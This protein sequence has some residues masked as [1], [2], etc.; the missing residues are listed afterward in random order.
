MK[1]ILA[2]LILVGAI[3]AAS[4]NEAR[5]EPTSFEI[6]CR[7]VYEEFGEA[8]AGLDEPIVVVS[9]VIKLDFWRR[10]QGVY[11]PGEKYV[12]IAPDAIEPGKTVIHEM[13][14]YILHMKQLVPDE[15]KCEHERI[16]RMIAG[17]PWEDEQKRGYGCQ[18]AEPD[19]TKD[20]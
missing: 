4:V 5:R 16:A 17:H 7:G 2:I 12:F 19:N 15:D 13:V 8:C 11:F 20:R 1:R 10:L 3:A 14:H 18:N 6:A 9:N